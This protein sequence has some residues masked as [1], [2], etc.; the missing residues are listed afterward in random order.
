MSLLPNFDPKAEAIT[1]D[2]MSNVINIPNG[3]INLLFRYDESLEDVRK[4]SIKN[5]VSMKFV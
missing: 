1:I 3:M 2:Q 4:Y 5:T